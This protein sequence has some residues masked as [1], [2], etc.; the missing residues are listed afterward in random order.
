MRNRV[1]GYAERQFPWVV[2]HVAEVVEDARGRREVGEV[3]SL[4][5]SY[6]QDSVKPSRS[7][8]DAVSCDEVREPTPDADPQIPFPGRRRRWVFR[9]QV[10]MLVEVIGVV[11]QLVVGSPVVG[12]GMFANRT[13]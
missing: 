3:P 9:V 6:P 4:R 8:D 5:S 12:S 13:G 7:R 2:H 11:R 10:S 1:V